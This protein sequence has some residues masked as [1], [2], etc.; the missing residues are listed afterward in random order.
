MLKVFTKIQYHT[1]VSCLISNLLKCFGRRINLE[2]DIS[3]VQEKI[4]RFDRSICNIKFSTKQK[5][6]RHIASVHKTKKEVMN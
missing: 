4:R 2:D 1:V 6:N 5:A 3:T